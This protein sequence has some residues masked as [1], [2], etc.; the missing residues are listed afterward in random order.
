MICP[1]S[2]P[3]KQALLEAEDLDSRTQLLIAIMEMAAHADQDEIS[4]RH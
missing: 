3:E 1:F 2:V 4:P